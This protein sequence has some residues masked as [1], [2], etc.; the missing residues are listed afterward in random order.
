MCDNIHLGQVEVVKGDHFTVG[1]KKISSRQGLHDGAHA[2]VVRLNFWCEFNHDFQ[3]EFRF[4]K[5]Q[6]FARVV[7]ARSLQRIGEAPPWL[8]RD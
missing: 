5:G 4:H 8:R 7:N 1:N 2:S 3:L 6:T